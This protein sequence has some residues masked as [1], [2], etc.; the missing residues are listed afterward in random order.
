VGP[1]G[2]VIAV[3]KVPELVEFGRNNC[4]RAGC[5]NVTFH[6][7]GKTF[8]WLE[9]APYDRILVSAAATELP[10]ELVEQLKPGGRMV[11]PV[12]DSILTINKHKDGELEIED[13]PGFAFVPLI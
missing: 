7:A 5:K 12:E 8:G 2:A 1:K 9:D 6:Q 13:N 3:E 11:I 4:K 10:Q